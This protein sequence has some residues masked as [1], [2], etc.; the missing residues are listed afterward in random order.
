MTGNDNTN[1]IPE[2]L[3]VIHCPPGMPNV[4][5]FFMW[6]EELEGLIKRYYPQISSTQSDIL[7]HTVYIIREIGVEAAPYEHIIFKVRVKSEVNRLDEVKQ[8]VL[9]LIDKGILNVV[10]VSC[11]FMTKKGTL[12]GTVKIPCLYLQKQFLRD[13]ICIMDD[14]FEAY[15]I[16]KQ[17]YEKG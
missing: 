6:E 11:E 14:V 2:K 4:K 16:R 10:D 3:D 8:A 7:K 12:D 5:M 13:A 9:G 1:N 15:K 17:M